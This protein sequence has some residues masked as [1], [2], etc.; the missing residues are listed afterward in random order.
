MLQITSIP[1]YVRLLVLLSLALS[2]PAIVTAQPAEPA[3]P[4]T[5]A[6][7]TPASDRWIHPY[8]I[9]VINANMNSG[10]LLPGGVSVFALP[11]GPQRDREQFNIS[12]ANSL[13]GAAFTFP[14]IND[15]KVGGK[16]DLTLR[17]ANPL[18]NQNT[19][20]PLFAN[21]YLDLTYEPVRFV[22][23][24]AQDVVS[25]LT[26]TT[27]NFYPLSYTP[28]SLGFFRPQ[29]R[30]ETTI[31]VADE[32]H[33][34]LQAA[35][36]QPIQTFQI[37]DEAVATQSGWPD[38]Q[39]RAALAAGQANA[40][41]QRKFELGVWGHF[42]ERSLTLSSGEVAFNDSYSFGFD[43]SVQLFSRTKVQGEYYT[44]QLVADY[45]GAIF[46]SFDPI[47]GIPVDA[48]GFWAEV[49]HGFSE[50]L[51]VHVG[52]GVDNVEE[53]GGVAQLF[54]RNQNANFYGNLFYGFSPELAVAGELS[55]WRTKYIGL[56]DGRPFRFELSLIYKWLGR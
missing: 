15:T 4:G 19:F 2:S 42:G 48:Q 41:G 53:E 5:Q 43:G 14:A 39:A 51:Q 40:A 22:F 10:A 11:E 6:A 55:W 33:V 30:V 31:G 13:F 28:G 23:G 50:T 17:G 49:E 21:V 7:Q 18:S 16:V 29:F 1:L 32:S 56:E 12:P 52:Y 9:F 3:A 34:M 26:P 45:M 20:S 24:Q 37:S 38:V 46:Q 25:P 8:A 44:G 47:S 36:A 27:L 54:A 35:M